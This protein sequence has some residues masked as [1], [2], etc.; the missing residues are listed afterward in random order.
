MNITIDQLKE[1][2]QASTRQIKV[3]TPSNDY[4][5]RS[6]DWER[7]TINYVSPR[8]LVEA[9]DALMKEKQDGQ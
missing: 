2:I 8:L 3:C 7:D 1:A 4:Y 5:A 6:E 9:L